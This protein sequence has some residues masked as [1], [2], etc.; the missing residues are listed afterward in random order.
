M[1]GSQVFA[2]VDKRLRQIMGKNV[3][4]GG[5]SILLVEDLHQLLPVMDSPIFK[6]SKKM[7]WYS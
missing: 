5:I 6:I 2:R 1:V 7:L 3:P 4:F